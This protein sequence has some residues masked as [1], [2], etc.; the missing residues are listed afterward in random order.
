MARKRLTQ[1]FPWLLPLRRKQRK[2]CFYAKMR[3]DGV[4]YAGEQREDRLPHRM[5]ESAC[6]MR[7]RDT[8]FDMQYQENKVF[9]L[10]L[11]ARTLDGLVIAP[12]ETFSFWNRVRSADREQPFRE[13]LAEVNGRL[14][15]QR[16]GGLCQMSNLLFW[17]FLHSPLTV[18]ERHGHSVKDFPE[19]P[20]DAP[21]GVDATVS[22]GWLDLR[23]RNDTD[24]AFQIGVS[25]DGEHII[26]TLLRESDDGLDYLVKNGEVRYCRRNGRIYEEAEVLRLARE[27]ATL[28]EVSAGVVYRNICEIGY[29]LPEGTEIAGEG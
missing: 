28:R 17:V 18:T 25:F 22:E 21:L 3:F 6:P 24:A 1:L 5:F 14:V 19:P 4:R 8:G 10:R 20:S 29:P 2:L 15:T 27:R 16:G 23:V 7:N 26:G 12:G 11:A 13:G 9:N